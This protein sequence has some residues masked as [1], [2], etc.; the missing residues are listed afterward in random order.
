M[1]NPYEDLSKLLEHEI[2]LLRKA[3]NDREKRLD[4]LRRLMDMQPLSSLLSTEQE[5][6]EPKLGANIPK[7]LSDAIKQYDPR[8]FDE[9]MESSQL[10]GDSD[11]DRDFQWPGRR[12]STEVLTQLSFIGAEGKS[13]KQIAEFSI[14]QHSFHKKEDSLRTFLS[15][16]KVKYGFLNNSRPAFYELTERGQE[17]LLKQGWDSKSETPSDWSSEGVSSHQPQS[18]TDNDDLDDL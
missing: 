17:Y 5:I 1:A 14:D 4:S 6:S 10:S 3:L 13:F 8:G 7:T 12:L 16:Q 15:N 18:R 11:T 2:N 9:P